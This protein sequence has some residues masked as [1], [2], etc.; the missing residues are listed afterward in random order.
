MKTKLWLQLFGQEADS[1]SNSADAGRAVQEASAAPERMTWK[2]I[3]DDPEYA[4]QMQKVVQSR[5]R[6]EKSAQQ[7]L[8]QLE[9]AVAV[10]AACFGK[11]KQDYSAVAEAVCREFDPETRL[12]RHFDKLKAQLEKL[13]GTSMEAVMSNPTFLQ[14]TMPGGVSAEDAW[15]AIN[16]QAIQQA[17]FTA[18]LRSASLCLSNAIRSG[19]LRPREAGVDAQAST[20]TTLDYR[21]ATPEQRDAIRRR[22]QEGW[23]RGENI[24]PF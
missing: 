4:A 7:S 15:F 10:L 13:P 1:G 6:T 12:F 8:Q 14:L 21:T 19:S 2:Q 20:V 17:T 9:P 23:A 11:D 22:I 5:L 16:R 18:A 3:M 24:N